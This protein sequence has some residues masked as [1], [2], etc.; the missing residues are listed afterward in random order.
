MK[1]TVGGWPREY[2]PEEPLEVAKY[3][4]KLLRDPLL[5]YA[6]ATRDLVQNAEKSI[7]QN[8]EIDLFEE[9]FAGEQPEHMSE[10]ISTKTVM[11]FK[12]PNNIKRAATKI[13]WH[14]DASTEM[15]VGVSYAQLRFQQMPP[16]MPKKSYIWN[17]NNPNFPEKTLEGQ[18]PLCTMAFNHKNFDIVVAGQYNGA[19]SFYDLRKGHSSGV[20]KPIDTT[21]LEKS[22]H[23][24]VYGTSWFTPSKQGNECVSTSTDGR[25]IWWDMRKPGEPVEVLMLTDSVATKDGPP[26]KILGGTCLDYNADAAP[27]KYMV[28]TEQGY[29]IQAQRRKQAEVSSRFGMDGGRHHGP[30]YSMQRNPAHLKYFLTIGDWSAKIWSEEIKSP[31]MQ[32]RY[33]NSYLTDGC[34]SPT[35]PGIFYLTRMDGFLDVWDIFYRQN[36]IAYSQKISDAVLTSIS[37]NGSMAAIGDSDGTVSMMSLCRALYDQTL[38]PK[39]KEVMQQIFE[40]EFRREKNLDVAKKAAERAGPPKKKDDKA[41]DKIAERLESKLKE[42]EAKFFEQ[43]PVEEDEAQPKADA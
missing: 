4:K 8:N 38:Q 30:V 10:S 31:I 32:T 21:V 18:S 11:I 33:H 17:L 28:G 3:Q 37:V 35:R 1:H 14:P 13:V 12:D 40:R 23:D 7:K 34:W 41:K 43:F 24:P 9:Y 25:L 15:R 16:N 6:H 27:M 22:H 20:V 42:I 26:P 5:S 36:E 39:E 2:D 19:L 29:I